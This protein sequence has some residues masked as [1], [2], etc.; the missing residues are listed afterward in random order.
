MGYL[1][2]HRQIGI[3]LHQHRYLF[4]RHA[5]QTGQRVEIAFILQPLLRLRQIGFLGV[6]RA[7]GK[8]GHHFRMF[9]GKVLAHHPDVK[10]RRAPLPNLG[11]IG[12]YL[13]LLG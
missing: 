6:Q 10:R 12:Q 3:A 11:G 7:G 2:R 5:A 8:G 1:L 13:A 9:F 4:F